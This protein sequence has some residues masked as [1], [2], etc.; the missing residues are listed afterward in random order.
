M[1]SGNFQKKFSPPEMGANLIK[2]FHDLQ[3][4]HFKL[5]RKYK[6]FKAGDYMAEYLN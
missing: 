2:M 5:T 3:H 6:F 1:C 4:E